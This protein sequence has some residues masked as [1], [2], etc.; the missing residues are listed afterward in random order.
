[1]VLGWIGE[2]CGGAAW[3]EVY[4]RLVGGLIRTLSCKASVSLNPK[5]GTS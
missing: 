1:M 4:W 2:N 3:M 5:S